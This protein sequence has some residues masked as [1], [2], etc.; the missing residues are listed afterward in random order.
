MSYQELFPVNHTHESS[1]GHPSAPSYST[2]STRSATIPISSLN[3]EA[4]PRVFPSHTAWA[5]FWYGLAPWFK[6]RGYILHIPGSRSGWAEI[7]DGFTVPGLTPG[8]QGSYFSPGNPAAGEAEDGDPNDNSGSGGDPYP[9]AFT[10]SHTSSQEDY[11]Y[12]HSRRIKASPPNPVKVPPFIASSNTGRVY[13]AQDSRGKHVS[14]KI[15]RKDS[16]QW[17]VVQI[18]RKWQGGQGQGEKSSDSVGVGVL[19]I[20]DILEYDED[21][22]IGTDYAFIIMPR[23]GDV[24]G[25]NRLFRSAQ[26][27]EV[28]VVDVLR[29]LETLHSLNIAHRDI[30]L[31]NLVMNHLFR[32]PVRTPRAIQ[33]LEEPT[34]NTISKKQRN[35]STAA[36]IPSPLSLDLPHP[37]R[38]AIIDFDFAMVVSPL[39]YQKGIGI[40]E[41]RKERHRLP[42]RLAWMQEYSAGDVA[43]GELVYDPFKYDVGVLG[44]M[45]CE[46]VEQYIHRLPYL[47]PLLDRMTTH[48][49]KKRFTARE[50]RVF[51]ETYLVQGQH[52][53][54]GEYEDGD[55]E[56]APSYLRVGSET[57]TGVV[58]N[59]DVPSSKLPLLSSS[60][61]R[62]SGRSRA[63]DGSPSGSTTA[64]TR[65]DSYTLLGR[66]IKR[67][68]GQSHSLAPSVPAEVS[69][70]S[71]SPFATTAN[72]S[73]RWTRLPAEF[74]EDFPQWRDYVT[75]PLPR[76]KIWLRRVCEREEGRKRVRAVRRMLA[77]VG[78][79]E[80]LMR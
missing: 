3:L 20:L 43:Q 18:V 28:F 58:G 63:T 39:P 78:V 70:T 71:V 77:L 37:L 1:E 40:G 13:A 67:K 45:F 54:G 69:Y 79:G 41:N 59:R 75:P 33:I 23:W 56:S 49:L 6:K 52:R 11:I 47:V 61:T 19:P 46:M 66:C 16:E 62:N 17:R 32:V 60:V 36:A 8:P 26:D 12:D 76:W 38:F 73:T 64:A 7:S 65:K 24:P 35:R 50:A 53:F 2:H 25:P 51:A 10:D 68:T 9:Y 31:N 14:I 34:K 72:S 55:I 27:V 48:E 15:L 5:S 29:G 22:R 21:T 44:I 4:R 74:Y 42:S 57:G 30:K 80:G